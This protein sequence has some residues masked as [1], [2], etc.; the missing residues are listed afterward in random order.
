M[1]HKV[2]REL[3]LTTL[4]AQL[5]TLPGLKKTSRRP[6]LYTEIDNSQQPYL[7]MGAANQTPHNDPSGTPLWYELDVKL[8]L[9]VWSANEEVP[10]SLIINKYLDYLDT[11]L[12]PP[13]PGTPWPAGFVSLGGLVKHVWVVDQIE[14]SGDVLGNQGVAIIPLRILAN[15]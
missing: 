11:L 7:A 1:E 12:T 9:Y 14:T 13:A 4:F 10:P 6:Q 2:D 8:Y 3:I 5:K 15:A